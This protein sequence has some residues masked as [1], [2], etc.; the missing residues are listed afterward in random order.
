MSNTVAINFETTGIEKASKSFETIIKDTQK[1]SSAVKKTQESFGALYRE[2]DKLSA[3]NKE[4]SKA[5]SES[6]KSFESEIQIIKQS[7]VSF[8]YVSKTIEENKSKYDSLISVLSNEQKSLEESI[9]SRENHISALSKEEESLSRSISKTEEKIASQIYLKNE[10]ENSKKAAESFNSVT[11]TNVS[12]LETSKTSIL[13]VAGAQKSATKEV[14]ENTKALDENKNSINAGNIL[15]GALKEGLGQIP[16]VGKV[17]SRALDGIKGSITQVIAAA[18]PVAGVTVAIGL[19]GAGLKGAYNNSKDLQKAFDGLKGAGEMVF[20]PMFDWLGKVGN[21]LAKNIVNPLKDMALQAA[22]LNGSLEKSVE[23]FKQKISEEALAL[24]HAYN[25]DLENYK[26][27]YTDKDKLREMTLA[28]EQEL[29]SSLQKLYMDSSANSKNFMGQMT[30]S[31]KAA[32]DAYLDAYQAVLNWDNSMMATG[33]TLDDLKLRLEKARQARDNANKAYGEALGFQDQYRN[34]AR[35]EQD[36]IN[37][38]AQEQ[39]KLN[40]KR[41][42]AGNVME[43][44]D[45]TLENKIKELQEYA[46][47]RKRILD[48]LGLSEKEKADKTDEIDKERLSQKLAL[49]QQAYKAIIENGGKINDASIA[50]LKSLEEQIT[51]TQKKLDGL[52]EKQITASEVLKSK[53]GEITDS[54]GGM[55]KGAID[56]FKSL[57]KSNLTDLTKFD[58]AIKISEENAKTALDNFDKEREEKESEKKET[59]DTDREERIVKLEE[60][61]ER[62]LA[63]EDQMS[64]KA[65][66]IKLK[67]LKKEKAEEDKKLTEDEKK[68]EEEKKKDEER[69][70]IEIK[71]QY[72]ISVAQYNRDLAEH[73]NKI[74]LAEQERNAAIAQG[75]VTMAQG[76]AQAGLAFAKTLTEPALPFPANTIMAGILMGSALG[77][78]AGQAAGLAS[79]AQSFESIKS[80][81]PKPPNAP[82]FA[83]GTGGYSLSQGSYAIVGEQGPEMVRQKA[84]G[85]LEVVSTER[86]K[87]ITNENGNTVVNIIMQI[88]ELVPQNVLA[89][90]IRSMKDRDFRYALQ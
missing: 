5:V 65:I 32:S 48:N 60:E 1:V 16:V 26:V 71:G 89:E 2:I 54:I 10:I 21:A 9:K 52:G 46:D 73:Q 58:E 85:D 39:E 77:T 13:N 50:N 37:K 29:H 67:Q 24:Q 69:K 72:D 88:Q 36:A 22:A 8:Q 40:K 83:Y 49:E 6:K 42:E 59:L 70:K 61:Y 19:L 57:F 86:T 45:K 31:V 7:E 43:T 18:G 3:Q 62:S 76:A 35:G 74:K 53:A 25:Q 11:E 56:L 55:F 80:D 47:S 4:L 28:R 68:K 12:I 78:V 75:V 90:Y 81:A 51:E 64:A 82:K 15:L 30:E 66:D 38:V 41:T 79:A 63:A 23:E 84:G 20:K 33:Q 27:V 14:E 44:K 34:K 17:A 87:N